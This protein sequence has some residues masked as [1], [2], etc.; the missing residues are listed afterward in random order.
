MLLIA[1]VLM[2]SKDQPPVSPVG[3]SIQRRMLDPL[4]KT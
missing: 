4:R 3:A 2:K 1:G